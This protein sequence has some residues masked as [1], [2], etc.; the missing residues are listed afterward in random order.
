[1]SEEYSLEN[2][3]LTFEENHV[4]AKE[5][6]ARLLKD[7]IEN[8]PGEPLQEWFTDTFSINKAL[9]AICEEIKALKDEKSR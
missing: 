8:C 6:N 5:I 9:K 2:L 4:K 3:I 1:M 7:L